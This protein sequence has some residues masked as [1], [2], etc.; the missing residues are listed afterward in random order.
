MSSKRIF[1]LAFHS[2]QSNDTR[3]RIHQLRDGDAF[4][5]MS[6]VLY[7]EGYEYGGLL[8]NLP[9]GEAGKASTVDVS[10]LTSSDLLVMNTRPPMDDIEEEDKKRVPS[11]STNLEQ[12]IFDA[13]KPYLAKC[14]RSRVKLSETIARQLPEHFGERAYIWFH[15]YT[16]GSYIK[17]R[18][19][20][21]KSWQIPSGPNRTAFYLIRIPAIWEGGPGLL[22]T[23]G[24]SGTETLVWS[25]LLR[26]RFP[27]W[28]LSHEF[29]M[30]EAV[31]GV[32]PQQPTDL[33]F[34]DDWVVTPILQLPFSKPRLTGGHGS[35]TTQNRTK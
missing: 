15:E 2:S 13:L 27:E 6:P 12:S 21:D 31:P 26:T 25:Y 8:L 18:G 29:L 34:A 19:L 33:S 20:N 30:A 23:F 17:Y 28:V 5:E 16:D 14:A 32:I 7:S 3:R 11:S 9:P 35:P 1:R 24:M 22:A 10:F 4:V